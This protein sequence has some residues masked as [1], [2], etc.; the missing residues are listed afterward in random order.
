MCVWC[1]YENLCVL[2]LWRE[3]VSPSQCVFVSAV[4]EE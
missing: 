2:G 3:G 1:V 4:E